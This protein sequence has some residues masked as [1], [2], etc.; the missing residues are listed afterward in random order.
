MPTYEYQCDCGVQFEGRNPLAKRDQ[1]KPCP[2]CS[3]PSNPMPPS[4]V[5][6]HFTKSVTGAG[7]QNTGIQGL[8]AHIDRTIGQSSKQGWDVA[9][10]RKRAKEAILSG[11]NADGH[12]ISKNLDG[13]YR[14]MKPEERAAHERSQK[15]HQA[16][17]EWKRG[18]RRR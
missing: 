12:D 10:Q 5:Q 4:T 1:P 7:P 11:T 6:G 17:G 18:P 15:I 8:D 9:E 3:K 13:T 16:A 2:D 14:I